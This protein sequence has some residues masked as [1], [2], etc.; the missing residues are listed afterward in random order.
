M[1]RPLRLEYPGAVYHVT[2]RGNDRS[3]IFHTVEDRTDLLAVLSA[4][5]DRHAV[6]LHAYVLM[7]NHFH[8]V[9]RTPHGNLSR[10]MHDVKTGFSVWTN[11]RNRRT[12][13]VFEG[14]FKAIAMEEAGYLRS[15]SAY[16]HLNPVRVSGWNASRAIRGAVFGT[17][18]AECR[19]IG[20]RRSRAARCG[21]PWGRVPSGR[22]GGGIARMCTGG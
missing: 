11:K 13:H 12:G 2:A 18:R 16:V 14:R 21:G 6:V 19:R 20:N 7:D 10:F 22:D 5:L 8:V 4:M 15:V 1:A 17:I 3:A 9:V